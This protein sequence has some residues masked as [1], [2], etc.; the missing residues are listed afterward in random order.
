MKK[1]CI[2]CNHEFSLRG[3][4]YTRHYNVCDGTYQR[5]G[6]NKVVTTLVC[7]F[8]GKECKNKNSLIN[9]ERMCKNNPNR[10]ESN[11]KLIKEPWNKGLDKTD[12]RVA[13]NALAVS[14]AK[15]GKPNNTIWTD[16]LRKAK[17]ESMKLA[18]ANHPDSYSSGNRGRVKRIEFDGI[19]FQG[20]WELY[21]YQWCKRNNITILKCKE[22][23]EYEWDGTR[24][25]FPD[26]ILPDYDY[27][28]EV[29]GY[30]TERDDAKWNQFP[31]KL[32]VVDAKDINNLIND[33]YVL[34]FLIEYSAPIE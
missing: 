2:K 11:F 25:Y 1:L 16:E 8:C 31:H 14:A 19:S 15:K 24:K 27:Y 29:K 30:K 3:G 20:K 33:T 5:L 21:F 7:Q 23:F 9:H 4:N 10:Q 28:V 18:V 6:S 34:P 12:P 13:K 22:W 26:F 17:S 32:L